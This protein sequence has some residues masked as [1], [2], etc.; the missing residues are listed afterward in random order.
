MMD[1]CKIVPFKIIGYRLPERSTAVA[2]RGHTSSHSCCRRRVGRSWRRSS[3]SRGGS[4]SCYWLRDRI[5]WRCNIVSR[6]RS[7]HVFRGGRSWTLIL[8]VHSLNR[9]SLHHWWGGH[10]LY[11]VTNRRR[12]GLLLYWGRSYRIYSLNNCSFLIL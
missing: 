3:S 1:Q 6:S 11:R 12:W 5:S 10:L 9:S 7:R 8:L 4:R 2:S